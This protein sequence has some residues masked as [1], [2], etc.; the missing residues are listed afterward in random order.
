MLNMSVSIKVVQSFYNWNFITN[1]EIVLILA[2]VGVSNE[3]E[4]RCEQRLL[5]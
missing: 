4:N 3:T 5:F 1:C 2:I